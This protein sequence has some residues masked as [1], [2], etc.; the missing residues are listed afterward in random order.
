MVRNP[1]RTCSSL[2]P[3]LTHRIL[4]ENPS[5]KDDCSG[6]QVGYSYC[7]EINYGDPTTTTGT[8]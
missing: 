4:P 7:V 5:V 8:K 3:V 6:I 1:S 2:T